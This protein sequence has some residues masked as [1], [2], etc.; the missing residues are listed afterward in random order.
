[1][2]TGIQNTMIG[3]LGIA[4]AA[5]LL[6]VGGAVAA[7]KG[8]MTLD[9]YIHQ[10]SEYELVNQA[11]NQCPA[12]LISPHI[13]WARNPAWGEPRL[14]IILPT[15][16]SREAVELKERFPSQVSLVMTRSHKEWSMPPES[17]RVGE[18]DYQGANPKDVDRI[19]LTL[20]NRPEKYDSIIIGK[21][22]WNEIPE[23][24]RQLVLD[25]VAT[26][27]GLVYVGPGGLDER[28]AKLCAPKESGGDSPR[29]TEG[30]PLVAFPVWNGKRGMTTRDISAAHYG[31]GRIVFVNYP[32][33]GAMFQ[34]PLIYEDRTAMTSDPPGLD[35]RSLF[36]PENISL[37]PYAEDDPLFYE[38]Y[39][40]LLAK[41]ILWASRKEPEVRI[42]PKRETV[43]TDIAALPASLS[44]FRIGDGTP[45]V[46]CTAYLEL[47]DRNNKLL[48]GRP[49]AIK[50]VQ[51]GGEVVLELPRVKTG[52]YMA[53]LWLSRDDRVVNWASVP[54]TV[55]GPQY[56][57]AVLPEKE[58]FAKGEA[59][60]GKVRLK[61]GLPAGAWSARGPWRHAPAHRRPRRRGG[62]RSGGGVCRGPETP[63]VP[64]LCRFCNGHGR[65]TR[66]GTQYPGSGSRDL[67]RAHDACRRARQ[68]CS[69]FNLHYVGQRD[70][71][72]RPQRDARAVQAIRR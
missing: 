20:L 12:T 68:Q 69:G 7:A 61:T 6:A 43:E 17:K 13:Q 52:L 15:W 41:A 46:P 67:G 42:V 59:I 29:I 33:G 21:V 26:G 65:G 39:H 34:G 48:L 16:A 62:Q 31:Q 70:L 66:W 32:D 19:A 53:D 35:R 64:G 45:F 37:T 2:Q 47:R 10:A 14:L 72:P 36:A 3:K 18:W 60:R 71:E 24:I 49:A 54:I 9:H 40:S 63:V 27:C 56:I 51:G 58:A 30:V 28:L 38:Y 23:T 25:R 55:T 57:D 5:L 4:G 22:N 50:A 44:L 8:P 11:Y 1:M